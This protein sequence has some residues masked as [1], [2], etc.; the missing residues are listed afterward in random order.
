[1]KLLFDMIQTPIGQVVLVVENQNL[2]FVD[3]EGNEARMKQLLQKRFGTY[4][5]EPAKNPFGYSS[6]LEAYFSGDLSAVDDIPVSTGGTEFQQKVWLELREIPTGET[7]SYGA[8]AAKLGQ[9]TASRA[10]G[11]TNGLN[12]V[13]IVLPCH[14]VIGASGTLTGY[15]GGLERKK[16]LLEH[17]G[18]KLQKPVTLENSN[19]IALF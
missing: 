18:V 15:A 2:C 1:M 6:K 4:Q 16:W 10:V 8:M 7:R 13:S 9:P 19:Q 5:L 14:R 17:E 11:M 3:F 12:P